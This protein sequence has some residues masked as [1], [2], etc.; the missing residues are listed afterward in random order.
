VRERLELPAESPDEFALALGALPGAVASRFLITG[1]GAA[2]PPPPLEA[3][4]G[5]E[6]GWWQL[7]RGD[8]E[9][10]LAVATSTSRMLW[11]Q[12]CA[13]AGWLAARQESP[14]W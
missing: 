12:M 1:A 7:V 9:T 3:I 11:A 8:D 2:E 13:S 14:A 5:A 4:D 10:S 6:T